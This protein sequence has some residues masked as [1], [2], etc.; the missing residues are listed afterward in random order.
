M[1]DKAK[2]TLQGGIRDAEL[3]DLE[4]D[5]VAGGTCNESCQSGCS[6]CCESGSANR[7]GGDS[8]VLEQVP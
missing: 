4:L 3:S 5:T 1:S 7:G 6:M 8:E 2:K